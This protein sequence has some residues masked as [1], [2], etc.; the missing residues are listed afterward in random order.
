MVCIKII[1]KKKI[2]VYN[3]KIK[4][5]I[6]AFLNK[7]WSLYNTL[8]QTCIL[9]SKMFTYS[10]N[11]NMIRKHEW[12]SFKKNEYSWNNCCNLFQ[13]KMLQNCFLHFIWKFDY[14]YFVEDFGSNIFTT[15]VFQSFF[16][17]VCVFN[18]AKI[19]HMYIILK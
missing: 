7:H 15:N 17:C 9:Y 19:Y 10:K 12:K 5:D 3:N 6:E 2:Q 18:F 1:Y 11:Y 4:P 13:W 14:S 8:I 16:F